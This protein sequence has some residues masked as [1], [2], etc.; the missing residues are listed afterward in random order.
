MANSIDQSKITLY[1]GSDEAGRF[2]WSP[3]VSKVEFRLR[4]SN[5]TY[6]RATGSAATG[7]KGKI[8]YVDVDTP[9]QVTTHL[10]DSTLILKS[11]VKSELIKDVNAALSPAQRGIDLAIRGLLEEK[12]YFLQ[13]HERWIVNYES[14]RDHILAAVPLPQRLTVGEHVKA[15]IANKLDLQG[16]GRFTY[17]EIREAI[18]DIWDG[19]S[20]LLEAAKANA[21]EGEVFWVLG[22]LEP[23][24]ADA[25]VF[26]FA[27]S[28]LV[29]EAGPESKELVRHEFPVVV[30]YAK[31]I[32][33]KWFEDY[34]FPV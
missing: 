2:V 1:R 29:V 26:G 31:R 9:G 22:G 25:T 19:L 7:P 18:R 4:T 10:A 23:S 24:E 32:W 34:A 16:T 6:A 20:G 13:A 28:V 8:P 27:V 3:F 14:M 33:E 21:G 5:T 15:N 30:E 11:L 12:L 17:P